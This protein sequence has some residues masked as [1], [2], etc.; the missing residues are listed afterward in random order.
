[1]GAQA[2]VAQFP[3]IQIEG[4]LADESP[5]TLSAENRLRLTYRVVGYDVA[6]GDSERL[7]QNLM[8]L[9]DRIATV[10]RFNPTLD[11]FCHDA[12]VARVVLGRLRGGPRTTNPVFA[13][14]P[15]LAA[16]MDVVIEKGIARP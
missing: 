3:A 8:Q 16:Q 14:H 9:T 13:P 1:V 15:I 12:R 6:L 4:T 10:M 11:G 5:W 2:S 7:A